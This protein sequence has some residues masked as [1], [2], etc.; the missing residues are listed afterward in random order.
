MEAQQAQPKLLVYTREVNAI[1]PSLKKMKSHVLHVHLNE[2]Q[3]LQ[4][5]RGGSEVHLAIAPP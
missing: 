3:Q 1:I 2:L 4:P 5:A